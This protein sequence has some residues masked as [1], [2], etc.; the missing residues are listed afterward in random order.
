MHKR[1]SLKKSKRGAYIV[2]KV[3][4]VVS[5]FLLLSLVA[6]VAYAD[7][8]PK[9]YTRDYSGG[10]QTVTHPYGF[11]NNPETAGREAYNYNNPQDYTKEKGFPKGPH[12]GY[13]TSTHKCRECHA[14]HRA[15]GKFK[16]MRA[17]TRVEACDWCHG[18]GAGSGYNIQMDNDD[19]FTQ[20]YNVG[21]TIGFGTSSGQYKAPDDTY[22]AYTPHYYL[23]GFSCFDCHSP[24]GNPQRILGYNNFYNALG[25]TTLSDA[26]AGGYSNYLGAG[27]SWASGFGI[28][29]P[30]RTFWNDPDWVEYGNPDP[31]GRPI[32]K[33][34]KWILVKNP[35]KEIAWTNITPSTTLPPVYVNGN[36]VVYGPANPIPAGAEI[37]DLLT[38]M[39]YTA[40]VDATVPVNKVP[41]DWERPLGGN[42][43]GENRIIY[44]QAAPAPV[45]FVV[46]EFCADCHDGN[47]GV[48]TVKA[49]VFSEDRA[50]RGDVTPYDLAYSHDN[51]P[52]H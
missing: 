11:W 4:I 45:V 33:P 48:S 20:E 8:T 13:T 30:G 27:A 35:N 16:L 2:R 47:A 3:F 37:P 36:A 12:G 39:I 31:E 10:S 46:S 41:T 18:G 38:Q 15:A 14:V 6:V 24:H 26:Q 25:W 52:R 34:G 5:A 23:G 40:S 17:D 19:D 21:H 1:A 7:V 9:T 50:I 29:N 22:P 42:A 51:Q 32:F 44:N 28:A 49:A 43:S